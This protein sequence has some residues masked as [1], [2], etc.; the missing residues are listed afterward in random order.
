MFLLKPSEQP[1]ISSPAGYICDLQTAVSVEK[2]SQMINMN[3]DLHNILGPVNQESK[4]WLIIQ[5]SFTH[6]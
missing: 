2:Q 1:F 3:L 6:C 5:I 4:E